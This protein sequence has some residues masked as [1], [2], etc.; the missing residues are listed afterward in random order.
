MPPE[1]TDGELAEIDT[2]L[3]AIERHNQGPGKHAVDAELR[4]VREVAA[5]REAAEAVDR[6][7]MHIPM[8]V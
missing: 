6:N 4:R 7:S 3:D 5:R 2:L 8:S 1:Y